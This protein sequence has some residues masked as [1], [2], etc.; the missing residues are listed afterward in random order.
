MLSVRAE[1]AASARMLC[2]LSR[3]AERASEGLAPEDAVSSNY[4]CG[5][6]GLLAWRLRLLRAAA[7]VY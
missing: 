4:L 2:M 6:Q 7:P 5:G 3:R 1:Q